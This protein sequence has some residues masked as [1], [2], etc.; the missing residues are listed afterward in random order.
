MVWHSAHL[1]IEGGCLDL[2]MDTMQLKDP[3]VHFVSEGS[4]LTVPLFIPS[5]RI[6]MLCRCSSAV[7]ME[8]FLIV[9]Y[10]TKWPL[11]ADVLSKSY[12]FILSF[13]LSHSFGLGMSF[14]V[15]FS[16]AKL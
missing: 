5:P 15:T 1:L 3:L 6:S 8:H 14:F 4:A 7:T 12:Q 13:H 16:V 10:G 2:S 9:L 11:Y